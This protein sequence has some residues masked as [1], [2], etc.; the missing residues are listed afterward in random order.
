MRLFII[1][2]V[3]H[4]ISGALAQNLKS[5]RLTSVDHGGSGCPQGSVRTIFSPESG[6]FS[7]LYSAFNLS[8]GGSTSES[9]DVMGCEVNLN[10][11]VPFGYSLQV[12]QADF[13]GS[14]ALDPGVVAQH[15]VD[16]QL[17]NNKLASFGFGTQIFAGPVNDV[18]F[19]QSQRP[20]LQLPKL[21]ACLP[22]RRDVQLKIRTRVKMTGAT[23]SRIG[24]LTVDSAD[25]QLEQRYQL[26]LRKCL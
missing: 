1:L 4:S 23:S 6:Q 12:D 14:V 18:Y 20:N 22:L 15:S 13:R 5:T 26:S 24:I 10:F 19:V 3:L 2:I 25:G 17:N 21:L 8:V 16:H 9:T 7:V 11:R